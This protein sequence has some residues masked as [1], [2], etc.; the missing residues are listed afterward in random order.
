[1]EQVA[2]RLVELLKGNEID[3]YIVDSYTFRPMTDR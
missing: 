2:H 1:V 3:A